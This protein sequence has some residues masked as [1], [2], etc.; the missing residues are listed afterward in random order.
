MHQY[1]LFV[2]NIQYIFLNYHNIETFNSLNTFVGELIKRIFLL[3]WYNHF[4]ATLTILC[5]SYRTIFPILQNTPEFRRS[6]LTWTYISFWRVFF[7]GLQTGNSRWRTN[8]DHTVDTQA[9][10]NWVQ[11][12]LVKH[13]LQRYFYPIKKQCYIHTQHLYKSNVLKSKSVASLTL[14]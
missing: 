10:G 3:E 4:R 6:P 11:I 7:W 1:I 13:M 14:L 9:N 12:T 8:M 2:V 5:R